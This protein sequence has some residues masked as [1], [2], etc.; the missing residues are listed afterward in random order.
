MDEESKQTE[1]MEQG[2]T[3]KAHG[4]GWVWV[5]V[6]GLVI[7]Y[8]LSIG[9]VARSFRSRNIFP[10]RPV[11]LLYTPLEWVSEH[12]AP[13]RRFFE[14]Y[15]DDLWCGDISAAR[16]APNGARSTP[17]APAREGR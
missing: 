12:C 3:G 2:E 9:P 7:V 15:V 10:S 11:L 4:W 13:A 17:A 1:A 16:K 8:V 14:W 6:A 5:V